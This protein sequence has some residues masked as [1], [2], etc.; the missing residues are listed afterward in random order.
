MRDI[1]RD[2]S[3]SLVPTV[4]SYDGTRRRCKAM[5]YSIFELNKNSNSLF[6]GGVDLPGLCSEI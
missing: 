1:M 5:E 4:Y 3:A 2:Q 6:E